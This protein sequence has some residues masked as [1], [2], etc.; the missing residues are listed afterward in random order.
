MFLFQP[1][2]NIDDKKAMTN[3]VTDFQTTQKAALRKRNAKSAELPHG[4][5]FVDSTFDDAKHEVAK[6]NT[7]I[8]RQMKENSYYFLRNVYTSSRNISENKTFSCY[9]PQS[10]LKCPEKR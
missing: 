4:R 1:Q 3:K 8:E 7:R 6:V 9:V 2:P 10:R 5:L